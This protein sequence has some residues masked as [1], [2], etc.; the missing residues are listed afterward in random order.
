[1]GGFLPDDLY[2]RWDYRYFGASKAEAARV[3]PQQRH[4]LEIAIE[5]LEDAGVAEETYRGSPTGVFVGISVS[6]YGT[7]SASP[8]LIFQADAYAGTGSALSIAANRISYSLDLHGPS[9]VR[10][11]RGGGTGRGAERPALSRC[12]L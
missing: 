4:L 6:D 8:S 3:D 5:A 2:D 7:L 12:W 10:T 1:M 9:M 11:A